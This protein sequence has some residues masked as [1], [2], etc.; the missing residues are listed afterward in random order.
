MSVVKVNGRDKMLRFYSIAAPALWTFRE[1]IGVEAQA[2][3]RS[4]V[5][6]DDKACSP[7]AC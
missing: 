2:D 1:G 6:A 5:F 4:A 7:R 3:S